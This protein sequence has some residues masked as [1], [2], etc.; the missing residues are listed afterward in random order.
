MA[1]F[2]GDTPWPRI[3]KDLAST[4]RGPVVAV[5]A[6][7]GQAAPGM[8]HLREGDALV[9]DASEAA[10]RQGHTHAPALRAIN[11]KGVEVF[12][13]QGLHAKVIT[14]KKFAWVGSANASDN[15]HKHLIE[16]SARLTGT[17]VAPVLDWAAGMCTADALLSPADIKKLCRIKVLRT[18]FAPGRAPTPSVVLPNEVAVLHLVQTESET[19]KKAERAADSEREALSHSFLRNPAQLRWIEWRGPLPRQFH[20]G[21]WVIDVANGRPRRPAVVER[22][23]DQGTFHL[24]WLRPVKT[25]RIPKQAELTTALPEWQDVELIRGA[26][27]ARKVLALYR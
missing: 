26:L 12:S 16:A 25:P 10:I 21:S 6:Y 3:E 5:V 22:I 8:L 13:V 11:R 7:V 19:T 15:S 27:K 23:S 24:V 17:D 9:C 18:R 14:S 1:T 2:F 4:K 20:R